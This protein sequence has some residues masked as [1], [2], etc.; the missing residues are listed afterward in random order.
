MAVNQPRHVG[1]EVGTAGRP[2]ARARHALATTRELSL[3]G[4][5]AVA[6]GVLIGIGSIVVKS[7]INASVGGDTGYILLVTATI[8]AA[9]FGGLAAGL[10]TL[11]VAAVANSAVFL[12]R[13]SGLFATDPVELARQLLFV[14]TCLGAVA[15]VA[16][17]RASRDRLERA[18]IEMASLADGIEARDQRLQVM[19][20]AS[21][22]GFW[23]WNVATNQLT[24]SDQIF[25]QH[26][27]VPN[28]MAPDFDTYLGMIHE[29]DRATFQS[30]IGATLVDGD[31]F[32][33]EYRLRLP[34]GTVRWTRGAGRVFRDRGGRP[35]RML[36]TGQDITE[37]R[38]VEAE[39][40]RLT[41]QERRADE[42]RAAF[43]DVISHELRTPVTTILAATEILAQPHRVLDA[44][45]QTTLLAD[46]R[47]E[48]ERLHRLVE[49]LL[50]LS[51][52]ERGGLVVDAEPLR[53][54]RVVDGVVARVATELPSLRIEVQVGSSLPV[55][56]GEATYVEQILR[57]LLENAAKYSPAGSTVVVSAQHEGGDVVIWVMDDGPGI[58]ETSL[59]QIFDLFYRAPEAARSVSGSGIGLFVCRSLAEAMGG[60]MSAHNRP[61]G[62]AAFSFSLPVL[63]SGEID[64]VVPVS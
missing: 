38:A 59:D 52:V 29:D 43:V 37:R 18:L 49:D 28:D 1:A 51:R 23:E 24:W 32:E 25:E 11:A 19:L 7:L 40:D 13:G 15:I 2:F 62:G 27:L 46:V 64:D 58:P 42:F 10:T 48:S 30:A 12:E 36:G 44:A 16:W 5:Q 39:R 3:T 61:E 55:V 4:V 34:D 53:V 50:V 26:G 6:A 20:A 21:R 17:R 8:L 41:V 31:T 63:L 22:T 47:A 57:N 9:W 60:R 45:V 54:A 33:L 56:S 35:S 14:G